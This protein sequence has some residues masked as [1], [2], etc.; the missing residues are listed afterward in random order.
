MKFT[1]SSRKLLA[2]LSVMVKV[3]NNKNTL[4]ILDCFLLGL[5]GNAL[6]IAATDAEIR[7]STAI[8]VDEPIS[9]GTVCLNAKMLTDALKELPDQPLTFEINEDNKEVLINYHNGKYS[10][11][12]VDASNYP[13]PKNLDEKV[14]HDLVIHPEVLSLG[15]NSTLF[16]SADDELRPVMNGIFFDITKDNLTFVASDGHKLIK[17]V[18]TDTKGSD[19]ASFILPKKAANLIKGMLPKQTEPIKIKFD[20]NNAFIEL[21]D[22]TVSSRFIEG[23]YPN[24]DSVI[25]QN[26]TNRFVIERDILAAIIKRVSVFGNAN[27]NLVKLDISNNALSVSAQDIDFSTEAEESIGITYDGTPLEIG[28]KS[29]FFTE[30]LANIPAGEVE[31]QLSDPSRAALIVPVSK[32]YGYE[33]TSLLMP[34]CLNS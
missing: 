34:M 4:P 12:G 21:S 20:F 22:F 18:S 26:N 23:R 15:I 33:H 19:K 29:T 16:A 8:E 30:L 1:V 31:I 13:Q 11:I 10:F 27:S 25:P 14:K 6:K 17:L 7:L 3:I 9:E 28:F 5:K 32:A 2:K 24:Y